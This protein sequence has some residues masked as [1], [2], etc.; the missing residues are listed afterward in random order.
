M[1][2]TLVSHSPPPSRQRI[3]FRPAQPL[4]R[5]T[6]QA[7]AG[8]VSVPGYDVRAL[9][10]AVVHLGVGAFHRAHQ[11]V[12]FDRLAELGERGWGLVGSG[13]RSRR[14]GDDLGAQQGLYTVVER[15]REAPKPRV[16]GVMQRYIYAPHHQAPLL[17][18]MADP[19]TRMVTLTITAGAYGGQLGHRRTGTAFDY[20]VEALRLRKAAGLPGFTVVSCDNLPDNGAAARDCVLGAAEMRDPRLANWISENVSFPTSMV[21]RI[22]PAPDSRLA[23]ELRRQHGVYDRCPVATETFT[24]WVIEDS[25]CNGRPPLDAVGVQFV[26]DALP[27]VRAKMNLLNGSHCA[28]GFFGHALGHI[29]SAEAMRDRL[30]SE[31]VARLMAEVTPSL[32]KAPHLH[33]P[34]YQRAVVDRLA[35]AAV[36]DPIARLCQR[37]S[38]R[39][40]N[41]ILPS[42]NA[43]LA[44]GH[45]CQLL[46]FVIAAWLHYLRTQD[47]A[48]GGLLDPRDS[49]LCS[50]ARLG[51]DDPRPALAVTSVFGDL[52]SHE[53]SVW[54]LRRSLRDIRMRG[55]AAAL[56]S[57]TPPQPR[58]QSDRGLLPTGPGRLPRHQTYQIG[59]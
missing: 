26:T 56:S 39:I 24:Q 10:P 35:D 43:A 11:A 17:Q 2:A 37:G 31:A 9:T 27:F 18:A 53:P 20:L 40:G 44:K 48:A 19:R 16:I 28:I 30:V 57:F 54:E 38:I 1:T 5:H 8:R 25:F 13:L 58:M 4:R 42:L 12:Y 33:L 45:P 3:L 34:S 46:L 21:D 22:T 15:G 52:G 41:Y 23:L 36:A 55:M 32:T 14:V 50:L 51:G 59:A 7:L 29:T 6:L 47:G 49:Q